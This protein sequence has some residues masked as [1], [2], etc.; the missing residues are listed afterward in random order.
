[1]LGLPWMVAATVRSLAHLRSLKN[2]KTIESA[3]TNAESVLEFTGVQEQ[4]V[5]GL[6]IHSLIAAAVIFGRNFLK[7]I[8]NA[9]LTGIFLYLGVS[10]IDKTDLWHRFTLF[11]MDDRDTPKSAEWRK[12]A[13]L[14]KTKVFTFIQLSLLGAMWWVKGTK[15]G[16]FF[17]VLI[18]VL[19]PIR[20]GLEKLNLFSTKELEGLDGEIA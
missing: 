10:S 1:M 12:S 11:F 19:A 17:P 7:K 4:R 6:W 18:G 9:V 14:F 2:Y 5:S 16:V 13:G 20:I 3:D 8:P 15:L